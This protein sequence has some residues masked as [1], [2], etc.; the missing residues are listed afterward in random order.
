MLDTNV[1]VSGVFFSGPPARIL[2]AWSRGEVTVVASPEILEEYYRVGRELRSR[3]PGVEIEP[4]LALLSVHAEVI[5][6][7]A[8]SEP[9][10][11]DSDDDKFLACARSG[12]VPVIVSGDKHLLR[13][14]G[15]NSISVLRP[16][17]FVERHLDSIDS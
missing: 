7:P 2:A 16:R 15:W 4:A 3:Y 13:V 1:F 17:T 10:C 14:S 12:G 8:L 9:V 6:A 5:A 11:E